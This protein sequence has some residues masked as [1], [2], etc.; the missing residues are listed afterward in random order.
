MKKILVFLLTQLT[1]AIATTLAVSPPPDGGYPKENTAE[2][3]NALLKL[4]PSSAGDN[5]A[6]GFNALLSTTTGNSNTAVGARALEKNTTGLNNTAVGYFALDGV[7]TE[8]DANVAIGSEVMSTLSVGSAN[9]AVGYGAANNLTDLDFS[10]N[11]AIGFSALPGTVGSVHGTYNIAIGAYAGIAFESG[12]NNIYIGNSG[13]GF[14]ESNIIRIGDVD[15]SDTYIAGIY[16]QTVPDGIDVIVDGDGH[17]GTTT[18][19][20]RFKDT[21]QPVD[22]SSEAIFS[23]KPVS[24]RYKPEIDPA[25]LPQFG[26]VAEDVEKVNAALIVRDKQGKPYSVRYSAVNIMLLNEFL[27]AHRN[28]EEQTRINQRQEA[29]I[30]R[31]E[32]ML[33]EQASQ[34]QKVSDRLESKQL[35]PRMVAND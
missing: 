22:K 13:G 20:A 34:I 8:G 5:T 7:T 30:G 27:K 32:K 23:L 15:H 10:Y 24:F 12:D 29:T 26:L 21:I 2:G 4:R 35:T 3:N 1:C 18:S 14:T 28:L 31:L 33:K 16:G 17:L 19:S 11:T 9:V 6:I 25:G